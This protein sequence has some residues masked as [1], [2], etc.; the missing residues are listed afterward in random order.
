MRTQRIVIVGIA[1]LVVAV[2]AGSLAIGAFGGASPGSAGPGDASDPDAPGAAASAL[3]PVAPE[4][5][6]V[7]AVTAESARVGD[8]LAGFVD[9]GPSGESYVIND[10]EI[11][12]VVEPVGGEA[13]YYG[14]L[15]TLTLDPTVDAAAQVEALQ[16]ALTE[17]GWVE[18]EVTD[19]EQQ[20]LVVLTGGTDAKR[21]WFLVVGA[22]LSTAGESV[23]SI[24]LASPDLLQ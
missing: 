4:P 2:L 18:R 16:T 10:D 19:T 6:T 7:E 13:L 3:L 12:Q 9:T 20:Y 8:L 24:Q 5:Y 11:A 15:H 17:G 21:S 22:D 14:V 1:L 23:V